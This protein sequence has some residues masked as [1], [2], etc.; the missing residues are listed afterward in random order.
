MT[1]AQPAPGPVRWYPLLVA[2]VSVGVANSV[3]F[4]LLSNL[5]DKFGFSDSGLGLIAGS[6]FFVGLVG[7]VLLA[8]LADRGHAKTL[9][10]AGLAT[11]VLGSVLFAVAN[12]LW[13]LVGARMIV[14]LS[15]S[16]YGPAARAI[17]I[18]IDSEHMARRLG[19]LTGVELAGF[20]TG[21]VLGGLL[22]GP[23]GLRVP[24]LAAGS[25]AL[26]GLVLL[27]PRRLPEPPRDEHHRLAFDLLRLPMIRAGVLMSVALFL[28]IGFYDATL[29]RYLTDLG[30]SDRLIGFTF[31]AYGVPFA[32]L[33]TRGGA[34]ASKR[35][36]MAV[37]VVGTLLVTP[38]TVGYGFMKLPILILIFS[39]F[40]GMIQAMAVPASQAVVASG[41]PVGRA[42]AAQ[43]LAGASN[44]LVAATT[45]YA[46]GGLYGAVGPEWMF[47]IAGVVMVVVVG[48][49]VLSYRQAE[50][51]AEP[52]S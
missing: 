21:P 10:L 18:S 3:I 35:G 52:I 47:S 45:A 30:G 51:P 41:A 46:A 1:S 22:V 29:D 39:A 7:Q 28:P 37:A 49:A 11:A 36:A 42:A 16:L 43:G 19:T 17:V 4:A 44:L 32:L 34:L 20:V 31:L 13:M 15:N 27:A 5:Q 48:L 6:G 14:G 33:A 40:E 2:A 23:A 38:I 24:F 25:I 9:V 12:S 50:R 8:P 26:V